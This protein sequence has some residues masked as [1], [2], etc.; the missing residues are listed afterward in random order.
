MPFLSREQ[1]PPSIRK[2]FLDMH[3]KQLREAMLNPLASEEQIYQIRQQLLD[4]GKPKIYDPASP[5]PLGAID[6]NQ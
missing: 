4:L 6:I 3:K 2:K 1:I 5:P